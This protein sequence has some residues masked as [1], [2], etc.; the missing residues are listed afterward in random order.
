[1]HR[2]SG[3]Q[4]QEI[5]LQPPPQA[6]QICISLFYSAAGFLTKHTYLRFLSPEC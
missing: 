1:M 4:V 3:Q 5:T 6:V 2:A